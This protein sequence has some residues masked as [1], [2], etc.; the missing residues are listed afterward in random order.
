MLIF[1][2]LVVEWLLL[3]LFAF[4]AVGVTSKSQ[5]QSVDGA[6]DD[7]FGPWWC[8]CH[9][10]VLGCGHIVGQVLAI[11]QNRCRF[12]NCFLTA[13]L[14]FRSCLACR[15]VPGPNYSGFS[16]SRAVVPTYPQ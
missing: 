14:S 6:T 7:G 1:L 9:G 10:C 3:I 11:Q 13:G 12:R 5:K 15:L 16:V 4:V 8:C 2:W